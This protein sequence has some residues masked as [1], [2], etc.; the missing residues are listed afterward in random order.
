MT[1]ETKM[2]KEMYQ[3]RYQLGGAGKVHR[4]FRAAILDLHTSVRSARRGGDLQAITLVKFDDLY[5]DHS[6]VIALTD[7]EQA[8]VEVA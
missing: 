1:K 4:S 7:A 2:A 6:H 5:S 3:V 8:S